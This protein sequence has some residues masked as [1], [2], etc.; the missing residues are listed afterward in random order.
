MSRA[1]DFQDRRK[2]LANLTEEELEARFWELAGKIV[3]PIVELARKNTSPSIERSVLLRMGF[4][5]IE[6][7]S[8]VDGA[9]DRGLM[10]K[11][12]GHIVYKLAKEKNINIR[13]AGLKLVNGEMWDDVVVLFKGGAN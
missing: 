9:I 4:S 13:E 12:V 3:D 11:G 2:H 1:D 10:G 8:I 6:A 5:S 7:K